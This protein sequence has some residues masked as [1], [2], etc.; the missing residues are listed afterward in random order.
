MSLN[1]FISLKRALDAGRILMVFFAVLAAVSA[2]AQTLGIDVYS[3][4]G[5]ITW[6]SVKSGGISFAWAKAT[7]GTTVTDA[8]IGANEVNGKAAGVYMG[9]YDFAHP[10]KNAPDTEAAYFWNVASNY[11]KADART[12][13]PM[14][15]YETF[16]GPVVGAASYADWANQWCLDVQAMAAAS[17]V[18]V[19]PVIYISACNTTELSSL[20]KWTIPW[21][22]DYNGEGPGSGSPWDVSICTPNEIWGSGV[23]NVWQYSDN[24]TISGVSGA[25]DEDVF[26]GSLTQLTNTLLVGQ[27][28]LTTRLQNITV[29]AGNSATFNVNATTSIGTLAYQWRFNQK[30]ISGAT[31]TAY[32][33]TNAQVSNAGAYSVVV[34]NNSGDSIINTAFL[35]VL[36]PLVN[37]ANS[38]FDP[39]NMV[40]WWTGD[41]NGYDIYG[42][43]NLTSIGNLVYTNGEIGS[44][45][46]LDGQTT[47][48]PVPGGSEIAP[49]WTACM[50]I[51]HQ[52]SKCTAATLLGDKLYAI[53]VEQYSN[54]DEVGISH[55][56]VADY[57]F[58][59]A[60]IVPLSQ[61][62]HLGF[63]ATTTGVTLYTNGVQEGTVTVSGFAL[64]RTYIGADQFSAV[65]NVLSDFMMGGLNDIQ[66]FNRALTAAEIKSIFNAGTNGLVRAPQFTSMTT[67]SSGQFQLNLIGQT[68]KAITVNTSTD[69]LNWVQAGVISNQFGAT[70][71]L[72]PDISEPAKFYRATQP[73]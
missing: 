52:R 46:R 66:L 50:W 41:G 24:S 36:G 33:V 6:T 25:C 42:T 64:P 37:G 62:T 40:N 14:L 9:A 32:T 54:T 27:I 15:D 68:G 8:N 26:N 65:T 59:P 63:V 51:F 18:S 5:T 43:N 17:G 10:E 3:G 56:G 1:H 29:A 23:W 69:L 38:P 48:F 2:Q 13:M 67:N 4:S 16:P 57:L 28:Q 34:T 70:N 44:A 72:D 19:T 49:N 30:N 60:Y 73:Y 12:I 58:S 31:T 45:F 47:G 22:A 21:I 55:S 39:S 7:E 20:D 53:K 11:I 61:W 71:Y 35:T